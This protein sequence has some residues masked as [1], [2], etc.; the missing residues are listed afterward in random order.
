MF[1]DRYKIGVLA[2]LVACFLFYSIFLYSAIPVKATVVNKETAQGKI[3]WQQYN[4]NSCHQIYGLGGYLGPDLT[5]VYS[6]RS[7]EYIKAFLKNG[8]NVMPNF[9]LQES[10]I[11]DLLAFLKNIDASGKSDPRTY[12]IYKN[13][14][15]HQESN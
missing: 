6:R 8:T 11:N 15:I 12:T 4:C 14:T 1:T 13:G 5:N 7:T 2:T 10:E 3:L 9:H